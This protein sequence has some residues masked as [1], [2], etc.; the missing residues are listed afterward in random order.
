MNK[1]KGDKTKIHT[2]QHTYKKYTHRHTERHTTNTQRGITQT[3][4]EAQH[5]HIQILYQT[6]PCTINHPLYNTTH[7]IPKQNPHA[8]AFHVQHLPP[9]ASLS[10][11]L[12]PFFSPPSF[13]FFTT[14][15]QNNNQQQIPKK[16]RGKAL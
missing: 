14:P 1:E 12:Q 7:P 3:H 5:K 11:S 4:R 9:N 6:I 15:K 16:K 13:F 10:L 8:H 2:L